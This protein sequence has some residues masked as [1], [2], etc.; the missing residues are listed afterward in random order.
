M[1]VNDGARGLVLERVSGQQA[2]P[3]CGSDERDVVVSYH[4]FGFFQVF[5]ASW[6]RRYVVECR[7]CRV[8]LAPLA[9]N[10]FEVEHG[11]PIPYG[12]RYGL[13]VLLALVVLTAAVYASGLRNRVVTLVVLA[14]WAAVAFVGWRKA[15]RSS[16]R[17]RLGQRAAAS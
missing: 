9:I 17:R 10:A 16:F 4:V 14:T 6:G 2:C 8:E 11:N 12:Q 13:H 7:H 15:R 1:I 5:C 3:H